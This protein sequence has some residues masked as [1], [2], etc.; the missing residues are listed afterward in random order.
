MIRLILSAAAAILVAGWTGSTASA[1]TPYTHTYIRSNWFSGARIE[2]TKTQGW[3]VT[4]PAGVVGPV[5]SPYAYP[6]A[7][8]FGYNSW[9]RSYYYD[10]NRGSW[11]PQNYWYPNQ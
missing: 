2:G 5:S 1:Q 10:S 11:I 9:S 3:P 7:S 4:A 6:R 8:N